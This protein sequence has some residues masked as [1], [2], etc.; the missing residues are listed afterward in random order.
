[1]NLFITGATGFI[2][3]SLAEYLKS[4]GHAIRGLVRDD[5]KAQR[6]KAR[7]IEPVRGD[8]D[9]TDALLA[10]A[11]RAD[12]VINAASS[13]HEKALQALID[14]VRG[15]GKPLLHT[16][17]SSVIGDDA[18]GDSL[19]PNIFDED[20]PFIVEPDKQARHALDDRVL[21]T[22]GARGIV[23]CNTMIYGTGRGLGRDSVQIPPLVAQARKSGVVRV[24][25][26]GLNRWSNVHID[27]V[28]TLYA[29]ALE[30]APAGAFY[31]VENGEASYAEIGEAIA[32]RLKLGPVR[33]WS[34]EEATREWGEGH[35]RYSFG[36]NSRVRAKRARREL[37]WAPRHAS[38]T[39]WI[40]DEMPV[41]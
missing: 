32:R 34:V 13:D 30:K 18:R 33:H 15:S 10:E 23:L 19:S 6:L 11:R 24:V 17:G 8:L 28:V 5:A 39:D 31:F 29:L 22:P 1:M 26:Q 16:S 27:D 14:G 9:S 3:G 7:G 36:S 41:D 12:G 38:V 25:G 20:T 4:R 2:G 40:R 35:A 37:G 21:A